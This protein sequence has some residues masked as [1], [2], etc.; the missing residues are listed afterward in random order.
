MTDWITDLVE[1]MGYAGIVLLMFLENVFPPIP[2]EVIMPLAGFGA[3]DGRYSLPLVI[4][5]GLAGTLL[6]ALFWYMIARRIGDERL[7]RWA[8]RHGRWITLSGD[9]IA[10]I[11]RWFCRHGTWAVPLAH[12]IPGL[13]TL[14]S[15]PAGIFAMPPARFLLLSALGAGVW[16]AALAIAGYLLAERFEGVETWVG[17]VSTAIMAALFAYYVWRV[18]RFKPGGAS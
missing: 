10:R 15:I 16:T 4:A 3:A 2:S 11:E 8:D 18:I 13:R 17:P 7:R 14:I 6:G 5:A 1:T 9:D 12:L